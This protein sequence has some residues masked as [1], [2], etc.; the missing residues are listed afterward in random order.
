VRVVHLFKDF[1]PPTTGGV[2]QHMALLCA[3]LAR[4]VEVTVLVPGG[5]RLRREEQ[6]G[7]VRVVRVPELGR[8]LS[9]PLCPTMPAELR[10]LDP[11][12]VHLHFP[13]PMGDLAYLLGAR[14]VPVVLWLYRPVFE[15]LQ[16][17]VAQIVVS[18]ET[19]VRSSRFL[20][21]Y[22]NRCVVLPYGIDAGALALRAGEHQAVEQ[23]RQRHG[24]R[25]VLFVGVLRPYKGLRVLME[26]MREVDGTLLV[27]GRG[28]Q[29]ELRR[30]ADWLGVADRV[31]FLGEVSETEKRIL[32]H[33]CDVLA[34]PS[35]D[36]REA[37]GI[38]QLEA[39]ACAKPVVATD[40]PT[41]VQAVTRHE[42]T[43]L[44]VPP[45]APG[46]LAAAL[47]R[48]LDNPA[49]CARLGAGGQERVRREFG[50]GTMV[51][52][53]LQL[54]QAALERAREMPAT[55]SGAVR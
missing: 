43:G 13:N 48:M 50:A 38:V 2:E 26:A 20:A 24:G 46:P 33:A 40:L 30:G 23:L 8:Y 10:R 37:F 41:G 36:R 54:Y 39:M 17:H 16:R 42:T 12:L 49:L 44:L 15:R 52:R 47:E 9:A 35:T 29:R 51:A 31:R 19:Y 6:A 5:S 22:R 3:G 45:N 25:V 34:L 7:A 28:E 4:H 21:P 27:V 55:A 32:L 18:S 14:R 1:Y 11:D 53:T